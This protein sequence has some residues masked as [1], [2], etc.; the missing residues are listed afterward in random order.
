VARGDAQAEQRLRKLL[1]DHGIDA[2]LTRAHASL[3]D[4]FVVA[5]RRTHGS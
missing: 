4:V 3:E 1:H 5:T 2:Q